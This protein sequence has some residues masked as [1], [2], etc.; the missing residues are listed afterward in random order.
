MAKNTN[1]DDFTPAT[2]RA[3]ER[4]ARGHCSNPMCRRLTSGSTSDGVG[5]IDIGEAA[6]ICA[7][8]RGGPRYDKNMTPAERRDAENGIWLCEAHARAV[9]SKNSKFTVEELRQWKQ[10]TNLNSWRSVMHNVPFGPGMQ[11]PTPD[12]ARDRLRAAATADLAV[13]RHSA[14]WPATTV[15]LTLKVNHVDEPLTTRALAGAVT[16]FDDLILVAPPGMGK[17]TTMF[18]VAE[19]PGSWRRRASYRAAR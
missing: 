8:A 12:V 3:I 2:R 4:Q 13:F 14:K 5:E 9:N 16:T 15:A 19:S 10:L 17:T 6:H 18:Q 1:R 7:A 11:I